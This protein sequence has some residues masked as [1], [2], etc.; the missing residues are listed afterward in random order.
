LR[1]RKTIETAQAQRK[2][3]AA[4]RKRNKAARAARTGSRRR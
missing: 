2:A 4:Q 1:D 3:V